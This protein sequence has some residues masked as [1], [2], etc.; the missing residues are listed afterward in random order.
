[1]TGPLL[2]QDMGLSRR[3]MPH[4][5]IGVPGLLI[6]GALGLVVALVLA[7]WGTSLLSPHAL[8]AQRLLPPGTPGHPLG[9]DQLG[10][11]VMARTLGGFRWSLSLA[12]PAATLAAAGGTAI[13]AAAASTG[14]WHRSLIERATE[15]A[16]GFPFL[17]VAAPL[18]AL[19]GR[20]Y[21]PL[22]VVLG[23][24]AS[25]LF[26]RAAFERS[27]R[28]SSTWRPGEMLRLVWPAVPV[29]WAFVLADLVVAETCLTFIGGGAAESVASWGNMLADARERLASAPWMLYAPA[30]A[31]LLT[32]MSANWLGEGLG[33]IGSSQAD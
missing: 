8:A 2:A 28:G 21:G 27:W 6:G 16:S 19:T 24:L 9:T 26:A 33:Q 1:M 29:V 17:V 14:G 30:T 11:D 18:V 15:S 3:L 32:V 25:P 22:L 12:L 4:P 7:A 31:L 10:R 13:G 20:G 5:P 23:V